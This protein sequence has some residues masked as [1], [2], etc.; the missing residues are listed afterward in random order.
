MK[1]ITILFKEVNC[2]PKIMKIENSLKSFQELVEGFIEIV[3]LGDETELVLNEEGKLKELPLNGCLVSKKRVLDTIAGNYFICS[4]KDDEFTS[5]S[6][7]QIA[8]YLEMTK[9]GLIEI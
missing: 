2:K 6:D 4:T 8:K 7:E 3:A 5:L 1:T 9:K